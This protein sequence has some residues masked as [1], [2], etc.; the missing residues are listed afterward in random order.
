MNSKVIQ[1]TSGKGPDECEKSVALVFQ[2]LKQEAMILG[3]SVEELTCVPGRLKDTF[4]S[5]LLKVNGNN[6]D[7]FLQSWKG[8]VLWIAQS[9]YRKFHK[10]KNWFIGVEIYDSEQEGTTNNSEFVFQ[11]LRSGGPG[12]Q[13]VNKVESSVRAIHIPTGLS[14]TS[15]T[16]RSQH[17]NKKL[18][19]ERLKEKLK[20]LDME[21]EKK[22]IQNKWMQHHELERGNPVR[23]FR[24]DL[25]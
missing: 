12:G 16:E 8:T 6:L 15:S 13:H 11:T 7:T 19:L 22:D 24:E 23:T 1:I 20:Q 17:M 25:I 2:K 4:A 10:R 14:V 18:A 5:I 21:K 9:P 3:I